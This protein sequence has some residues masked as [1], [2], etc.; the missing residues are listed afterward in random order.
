MRKFLPYVV[1]FVI[2]VGIFLPNNFVYAQAP[3]SWTD[4]FKSF[5]PGLPTV[6][7]IINN[8]ITVIGYLIMQF[9]SLFLGL[10]GI[11]L[12]FVLKYTV[13]DFAAHINGG[14]ID[15]VNVVKMSGINIAWKVMRDLMNIAFIFILIYEAL[16]LIIGLGNLA[17]I[18]KF[19]AMVVLASLL[20]N[21]SLFF[22]KVIIDASNIV[23]IGFYNSIIAGSGGLSNSITSSLGL[24]STYEKSAIENIQ[25]NAGNEAA[26]IF[27][28]SMG[29]SLLFIITA[30]VFFAIAIMFLVRY[31]VLILLLMSSPIGFMGLALPFMKPYANQWWDSLKGQCLWAPVYMIMT[32]VILTLIRSPGFTSN[33]T[34]DQT[35]IAKVFVGNG[36]SIGL[37]VNFG[38]II[39]LI[40]ASLVI[41]KG[42]AKKGSNQIGT[43]TKWATAAA[44]G[45]IMGGA[46]AT[47]R[48]TVGRAGNAATSSEWLKDKAS[49]SGATGWAARTALRTGDVAAKSSLDVRATKSF[50]SLAKSTGTDFGKVDTKKTN[51]QASL[52]AKNER[53]EATAKMLKPGEGQEEKF[54]QQARDVLYGETEE[55]KAKRAAVA[56]REETQRQMIFDSQEAKDKIAAEK[57]TFDGALAIT[58]AA[59]KRAEERV[60]LAEAENNRL[61]EEYER[62]K[63][64]EER[65]GGDSRRV[66]NAMREYE[67]QAAILKIEKDALQKRVADH[68][69]VEDD[70]TEIERRANK[71][72]REYMSKEHEDL[73]AEAEG[74]MTLYQKRAN[75]YAETFERPISQYVSN[76]L[77]IGAGAGAGFVLGGPIGAAV[78]GVAMS[79]KTTSRS[80]NNEIAKKIRGVTKEKKKPKNA[81]E[82][83]KSLKDL[84]FDIGDL[85]EEESVAS[86]PAETKP[87]SEPEKP[88]S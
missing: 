88:K 32:W 3:Q 59:K 18:K 24:I 47:M 33:N 43:A 34:G 29:A 60:R 7:E 38:V 13:V 79:S 51:F 85:E 28:I 52:K 1:I 55:A 10:G 36:S 11:F 74:K 76:V 46:A 44:G 14:V 53:A 64:E 31:L 40:I 12:N 5:L 39:G 19:I 84:G 41:S 71:A 45:A 69:K 4:Y 23:T 25:Q 30:F 58:E 48:N 54:K 80:E 9:T 20:I 26:N 67:N 22:T 16:K 56:I 27:I 73:I 78:G 50:G 87:E 57:K 63:R 2:L 8:A 82:A 6:N 77:K 61:K 70:I 81:K 68:K 49:Q 66:N 17:Q 62:I 65:P 35:N 83:V 75:Q 72:R 86:A 42:I 15:G 21:F 37:I